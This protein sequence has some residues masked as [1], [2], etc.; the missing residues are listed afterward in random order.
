MGAVA[1][2]REPLDAE[3]LRERLSAVTEE[4][5]E[6]PFPPALP[7][8]GP[9]MVGTSPAMAQ[10]FET[11][12]RVA[13]TDSTVLVTGESG[14]GKEVVA[15][16][17]HGASA[18]AAGP[19]VAIN[20]AAIP[21]HLLESELFGHERGAFTGAV[22]RRTGRFQRARGGTL[23]LDEIGDMSPVLQSKI[24]RVLEE[25]VVEPVGGGEA[26]PVDAR[27]VAATNQSLEER[28]GEGAFR[29]DLYY[30]LAVVELHLPPLRERGG[31]IRALAL[32]FGARFAERHGR[33]VAAVTEEA[34]RRLERYAWP[35]NV[36]ELRPCSSAPGPPSARPRSAW[37]P[38]RP[39]APRAPGPARPA[40][41][42]PPSRWRRWRRT[43]SVGSSRRWTGT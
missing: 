41:T 10:V 21:E 9:E 11:V 19:F 40:D 23:F 37:A 42:R 43:T 5:P 30:R 6:V 22:E 39:G 33:P 27:I 2:L 15:R 36:R 7:E 32:H 38:D 35:G 13:A 4:G 1:F 12:A 29:E 34:L 14:T 26:V 18:R 25:R 16:V 17:L 31:D 3:E 8:E 24:L 20:C 28:I